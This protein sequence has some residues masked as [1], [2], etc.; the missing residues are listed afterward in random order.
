MATYIV[1]R[2]ENLFDIAL[3]LYGSIEGIFN[4]LV[5]NTDSINHTGLSIEQTLMPGTA[6]QYTSDKEINFDIANEIRKNGIKVRNGEH[7]YVYYNP[8]TYIKSYVKRHNQGILKNAIILFPAIRDYSDGDVDEKTI[9]DFLAYINSFCVWNDKFVESDI[10]AII[11]GDYAKAINTNE[12]ERLFVPKMIVFQD[13][14]ETGFVF[15]MEEDSVVLIDWDDESGYDVCATA[16]VRRE[17]RHRY[18]DGGSHVI[19]VYGSFRFVFLDL[20][21][22]NGTYYPMSEI[23]VSEFLYGAQMANTESNQLIILT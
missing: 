5:L 19:K 10:P 8:E 21:D 18:K 4:L 9:G 12:P 7:L 2:G 1:K 16:N 15:K 3:K 17:I 6:L 23:S 14:N 13:G 22:I 11:G 20:R